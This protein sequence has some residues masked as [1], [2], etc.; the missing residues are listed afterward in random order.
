M[1]GYSN[2]LAG[3]PERSGIVNE[4][5]SLIKYLNCG[6]SMH[7]ELC[8]KLMVSEQGWKGGVRQPGTPA[9]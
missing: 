8:S 6:P 9:Q 4:K 5:L 1:C 3:Q 7:E 2:R